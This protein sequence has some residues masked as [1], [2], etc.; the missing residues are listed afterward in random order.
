VLFHQL[1][2]HFILLLLQFALQ[3]GDT[4]LAGLDLLVGPRRRSEGRCPVLEELLEPPIED[5]G[6]KLIFVA[7]GGNRNPISQVPT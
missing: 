5:R 6:V 7:Q 2:Q 3:E 1:R 4:L